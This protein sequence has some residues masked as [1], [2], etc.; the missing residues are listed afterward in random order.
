MRDRGRDS[1]A[2]IFNSF[3]KSLRSEYAETLRQ[4][5]EAGPAVVRA[6]STTHL[7]VGYEKAEA[8]EETLPAYR[9]GSPDGAPNDFTTSLSDVDASVAGYAAAYGDPGDAYKDTQQQQMSWTDQTPQPSSGQQPSP[10]ASYPR[11][12]SEPHYR[13]QRPASASLADFA[14]IPGVMN[15]PFDASPGLSVLAGPGHVG[16]GA[17]E[18]D[19]KR[20]AYLA[21][22]EKEQ[23]RQASAEARAGHGAGAPVLHR[24]HAQGERRVTMPGGVMQHE[25]EA[26]KASALASARKLTARRRKQTAAAISAALE[27]GEPAAD[28]VDSAA[29]Y[30][31]T[32]QAQHEEARRKAEEHFNAS[33]AS[34]GS[35]TPGSTASRSASRAA[36]VSGGT[37]TRAGTEPASYAYQPPTSSSHS[38][39]SHRPAAA[40]TS[41][42]ISRSISAAQLASAQSHSIITAASIGAAA[43][44][45][46]AGC[47]PCYAS[48]PGL[49]PGSELG[50]YSNSTNPREE[51]IVRTLLM[52]Q[53]ALRCENASAKS[54]VATLLG[55]VA[56]LEAELAEANE[57]IELLAGGDPGNRIAIQRGVR[58]AFQPPWK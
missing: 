28:A 21:Q 35:A 29:I 13:L 5:G 30:R 49:D 22:V 1:T 19:A 40:C 46:P 12:Y 56:A 36:I 48:G 11:P 51:K 4:N 20:Q 57:T 3:N 55:E 32:L 39:S 18:V 43:P 24:I 37:S 8:I 34:Y 7:G 2:T 38:L 53:A 9:A 50:A 16:H 25:Y 45:L 6:A 23:A 17:G 27:D 14:N 41:S 33:G 54:E 42:R 47:Q 44:S 31:E 15:V 58:T 26:G 10:S 52:E